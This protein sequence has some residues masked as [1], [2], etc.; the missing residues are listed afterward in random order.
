MGKRSAVGVVWALALCGAMVGCTK[1]PATGKRQLNL[2]PENQEIALGKQAA[3]DVSQSM[4]LYERKQ[5]E[6]YVAD[7]GKR[8]AAKSER[9]DLPWEFHVVDDPAVNAFALPGGYIFVTRGLLAHM[10][11]E[12]Q[13]AAVI[14]HEIGHVTGQHSVNRLSKQQVAQLGLGIGM[15]VSER[16]R[17][18]GQAGLAGLN[19]LFLKFSRDDEREA[20]ELGIRYAL[21][22]GYDV[23]ETP[24]VFETLQRVSEADGGG[25][26]LPAWMA[27]HPD[28]AERVVRTGEKVAALPQQNWDRLV[29]DRAEYLAAID[30]ITY[31]PNPRFGFFEGDRYYHPELRFAVDM[32]AGWKKA[33]LA[34]AVIAVS[35][36]QDAAIQI[37]M[38]PG[39]PA[40]AMQAFFAKQ[41][42]RA[43][44]QPSQAGGVVSSSY[45][46]DTQ[47]GTAGGVVSFLAHGGRTFQIVGL[48]GAQNASTYA[49]AFAAVPASFKPV[50]DPRILAMKPVTLQIERAPRAMTLAEL[51]R[52]Q[53]PAV[54]LAEVAR[55]N[56]L[57][58]NASLPAGARVK[59]PEGGGGTSPVDVGISR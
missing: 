43:A 47:Q 7:I 59:W 54:D 41:G 36:Q 6:A 13:L 19:L 5:L 32:P 56:A 38:V 34:E 31:G 3:A 18:F 29:V 2:V 11:N 35:P 23:R 46:A 26:R 25:G 37:T 39:S 8:M 44:G 33:N 57:E 10:A 15:A 55:L 9:P 30:G 58:A 42:V 16:V 27:T 17:Q 40:E 51:A 14:G 21:R 50:D 28:P 22:A 49:P 24:K 45:A 12:A 52:E 20:D 4:G 53:P 1:N 48:T